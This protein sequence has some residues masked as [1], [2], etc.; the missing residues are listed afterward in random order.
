MV[1]NVLDYGA[2]PDDGVDDKEAIQAA[3]DA[4]HDAGGGEVYIP[5]GVYDLTGGF[6]PSL[7]SLMIKSNVHLYGD[8]MGLTEL[9]I[10]DGWEGDLT[11]VIRTRSGVENHDYMISD[12]TINGNQDNVI[13]QTDGIYTGF[14]PY[15]DGAD[16][17][18]T[19]SR[20]E[21]MEVSRYGFDPHE[22]TINLRIEDSIAHHNGRDGFVAD[23]L[24]D[25][26]YI[27]NI[28]HDN[29]RHGFNAVT[30]T[31]QFIL[32]D[33][34][35]YNNG[36]SGAT[37]QR[38]SEDIP[39]SSNVLIEGGAYYNNK[40]GVDIKLVDH[41]TVQGVEIYD[42]AREGIRISGADYTLIDDNTLYG[43]SANPTGS[44]AEIR[45]NY[46]DDTAGITGT[47]HETTHTI[48]TNNTITPSATNN[49]LGIAETS[50]DVRQ[51]YLAG[52][53]IGEFANPITLLSEESGVIGVTAP[54]ETVEGSIDAD[55]IVNN[56]GYTHINGNEGNDSVYGATTAES[57]NG[58]EGDDLLVGSGGND[59]I[60]GLEGNDTIFG[61]FGDDSLTAHDG[62]DSVEGHAGIDVLSLGAGADTG[63]GGASNDTIEGHE[64]DDV[65]DGGIGDDV[66]DGGAGS[67]VIFG[68]RGQDIIIGG[69]GADSLTGGRSEDV[70]LFAALSDSQVLG[71]AVDV[72][73]DFTVGA[74]KLDVSALGISDVSA[75]IVSND[76]IDTELSSSEFLVRLNGVYE[77]TNDDFILAPPPPENLEF[78]GMDEADTLIGGFGDDTLIGAG[79]SDTLTGGEGSDVFR[80]TAIID[81]QAAENSADVI[82]DFTVGTDKIDVSALGIS[83]LSAFT[84]TNDGL[85]TELSSGEFLL[86]LNGVYAFTNNDFV[87]APPP[88][89]NLELIGTDEPD[90]LVGGLG[91]DTLI[92]VGAGDTLTGGEGADVFLL[93]DLVDS[94][95]AQTDIITDFTSGV[96]KIDVTAL[97]ISDVSA[98]TVSND[99]VDT[100]LLAEEF[101]LRL[102][103]VYEFTN[104]DFILAPPPE[105]LEVMGTDAPDM[106][107]GGLG[108]DTLISSI[109]RDT[110]TGS[111]G[112]DLFAY[113][114]RSHSVKSGGRDTITDFVVGEDKLDLA[115]L[116]ITGFGSSQD[117][118]RIAYNAA[119][120][121]TYI[122][123]DYDDPVLDN[124]FEITLS[125]NY[126]EILTEDDFI[127]AETVIPTGDQLLL[128]SNA[129]EI[130]IGGIGNDTL[131]G[132]GDRDTLTGGE[133]GD[134]F[135]Y[136]DRVHSLK[137]GGRDTIADFV[138][139]EDKI[140]LSAIDITGF[141]SAQDK[142]RLAYSETTDLTYIKNDVTDPAL[143][144]RFEITLSGN[145]LETLTE[146]D[147]VFAEIT[148]P[149]EDQLLL[150]T[151][152][153]ETIIGG[154]GNDTITGAGD[155]DTLTGGEGADIFTYTERSDSV[156]FGGRDTIT[157]FVVGEDKI[158]VS[159]L[160]ITGFGSAQDKVRIAY[161]AVT[162][163]TYIKNDYNDPVLENRFE[164]T[165]LGDYLDTLNESDFIFTEESVLV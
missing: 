23:Y 9:K 153:R 11:G 98:F 122:K 150:G 4:A 106:L 27:N 76:G 59:T 20:V 5:E 94:Q 50:E 100:E 152:A 8:G 34:I 26:I 157:D 14:K 141:G 74:D 99:D 47:F 18:V 125:G 130:L 29:V 42:N 139:G 57:I 24:I 128:G 164:I 84:V 78:L 58:G 51:T 71:N 124:R 69:Q 2:T 117:K 67:D 66:L 147:F 137:F 62:D 120:D 107:L 114:D 155:R 140:D 7:G 38:G 68:D 156:Q 143:E 10:I 39:G 149:T 136:T 118:V 44:Y 86:R 162:D 82:T 31:N 126:L 40:R 46:H 88:P 129:R 95:A 28:A 30:T 70:F 63:R 154:L 127:F 52:N 19:I 72:I 96:D 151:D 111:E 108:N 1:Y 73:T 54:A 53:E 146:D 102:N 142:V 6:K 75:F 90:I 116:N 32:K 159:A 93:T 92:G 97:S 45:V 49:T 13:G 105:N 85:D 17:N 25:S 132:A 12:L 80:F 16:Y 109:G 112:S 83:D 104:D 43:N 144:D 133:G 165:L 101:L 21:I 160:D 163:L 103:G 65:L 22:R 48:I 89:E 161:N 36:S 15:Q 145:Y 56:A 123:N 121:L 79:D 77:F 134:I 55:V 33:N 148:I 37:V 64:G 35:A 3:I 91:N 110:L 158:D 61:G 119:S 87:L 81:S 41:V 113:S 115:A 131:I 60:D 135:A 138:V